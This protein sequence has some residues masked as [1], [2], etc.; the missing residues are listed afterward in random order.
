MGSG[1][2]VVDLPGFDD[3][4]EL[5]RDADARDPRIGHQRQAYLS[6]LATSSY[7]VAFIPE[8][9]LNGL[10]L[11]GPIL[12]GILYRNYEAFMKLRPRGARITRAIDW[13]RMGVE[14]TR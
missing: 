11:S 5:A 3:P 13:S 14:Q 8:K 10:N 9:S 1:G 7:R 2:A 12:E 6:M 4:V